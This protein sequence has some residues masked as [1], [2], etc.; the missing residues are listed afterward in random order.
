MVL[1]LVL[2][3]YVLICKLGTMSRLGGLHLSKPSFD[4]GA[5][6]KLT[7]LEQFKADCDIL[8]NGPLCDLKEKQRAGLLVN[9]L[10][11]EATQILTSVESDVNTPLEVF[12]ALEKVF[13]PESNQTLSRFKFRN[14]KQSASQNC[15]SYMSGLRL[16]LPE[17]KY[18]NDSDEL[19]KDQFIFGIYNKEIQDH[20]LGEIKETD[21]SVR[22]LYEARKIE[23]KLAQRKMLG[24]ANPNL[25]SVDE[26]KRST[27]FRG[28]DTHKT[29]CDRYVDVLMEREIVLHLAKNAI[30]VV[31]RTTIVKCVDPSRDLTMMSQ[32]VTQESQDRLMVDVPINVGCMKLMKSVKMTWRT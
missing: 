31:E 5:S 26:L 24:I 13:R 11:R 14:M 6:D 7:E 19:L 12:E 25:V 9:W 18:R 21:N 28:K 32:G 3:L 2:L 1:L 22:A 17:C 16:A 8:F 15:D 20:L 29:E 27:N 23:S 30:S 10:G 4:W